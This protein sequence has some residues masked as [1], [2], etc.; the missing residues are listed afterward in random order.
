MLPATT[1][2]LCGLLPAFTPS[3]DLYKYH[4]LLRMASAQTIPTT[5]LTLFV[6]FPPVQACVAADAMGMSQIGELLLR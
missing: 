1:H 6:L 5:K 3:G 4:V 2:Q